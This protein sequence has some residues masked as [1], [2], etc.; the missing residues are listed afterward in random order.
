VGHLR[1]GATKVVRLAAIAAA[2]VALLKRAGMRQAALMA[3][4]GGAEVVGGAASCLGLDPTRMGAWRA[5]AAELHMCGPA[6][7]GCC[8]C[9]AGTAS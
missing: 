2:V 6:L 4:M 7:R 1:R 9:D 3:A 8:A 5:A